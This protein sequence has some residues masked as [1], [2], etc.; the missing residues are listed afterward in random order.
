MTLA[1]LQVCLL[2]RCHFPGKSEG[3]EVETS[4]RR[5]GSNRPTIEP[6]K[7][8][9]SSSAAPPCRLFLLWFQSPPYF[10]FKQQPIDNLCFK[11]WLRAV[12]RTVEGKMTPTTCRF[13]AWSFGFALSVCP[14]AAW[15]SHRQSL[16]F[17]R[18][19]EFKSQ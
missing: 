3:G 9:A 6:L 1:H 15:T 17:M 11:F 4:W 7:V 18:L 12:I 8:G 16:S 14:T 19:R 2:P 5:R 10:S 13:I